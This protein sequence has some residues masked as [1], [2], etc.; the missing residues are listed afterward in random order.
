MLLA[1]VHCWKIMYIWPIDIPRVLECVS[2][3]YSVHVCCAKVLSEV[4]KVSILFSNSLLL[5]ISSETSISAWLGEGTVRWFHI[6]F[7]AQFRSLSRVLR[8]LADNLQDKLD[9][10]TWWALTVSLVQ[11][12]WERQPRDVASILAALSD[13]PCVG[14]VKR[15]HTEHVPGQMSEAEFWTRFFQSHYFH[16]D[17]LTAGAKDLF[18]DC[19]ANDDKGTGALVISS[20]HLTQSKHGCFSAGDH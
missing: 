20:K 14:A 13:F 8:T 9:S 6:V 2:L 15:K 11:R 10:G 17:R 16:R 1:L 4:Q 18:A 19:A 12:L 3:I 7:C 5:L